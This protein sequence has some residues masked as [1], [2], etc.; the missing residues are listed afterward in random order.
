ML[1][2]AET[3][4]HVQVVGWREEQ[5]LSAPPLTAADR[6]LDPAAD[7][8]SCHLVPSCEVQ[9]FIL[10]SHLALFISL[11]IS[12]LKISL[13]FRTSLW[14]SGELEHLFFF[15]FFPHAAIHAKVMY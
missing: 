13:V 6:L 3:A 15:F 2:E 7:L 10:L 14:A 8:H 11:F 5:S 9:V 1:C 12:R 4:T